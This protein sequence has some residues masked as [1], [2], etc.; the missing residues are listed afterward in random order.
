MSLEFCTS[1]IS[2]F[3][4][5]LKKMKRL[6][7]SNVSI[8]KDS[9]AIAE[10]CFKGKSAGKKIPSGIL[11]YPIA[12][13]DIGGQTFLHTFRLHACEMWTNFSRNLHSVIQII[14]NFE[15]YKKITIV[16]SVVAPFWKTFLLLK[17]LFDGK[18]SI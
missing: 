8:S 2:F 18:L 11:I 14:Q 12:D 5:F 1:F 13:A 9:S 16:G 7:T 6:Q 10:N 17:Q 4:T 15:T 3:V